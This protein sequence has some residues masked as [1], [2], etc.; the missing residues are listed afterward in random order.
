MD[1]HKNNIEILN[2]IICDNSNNSLRPIVPLTYQRTIFD[3]L[4]NTS[5]PGIKATRKIIIKRF[6]WINV[7]KKCTE[8][9]KTCEPCQKSK[10]KNTSSQVH[11]KQQPDDSIIYM[12]I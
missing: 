2:N 5:H 1:L 7:N 9:A 11:M 6:T 3:L 12:W 10:I 8:W 4:H